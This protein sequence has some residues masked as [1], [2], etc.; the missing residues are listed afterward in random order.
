MKPKKDIVK[1]RNLLKDIFGVEDD[2]FPKDIKPPGRDDRT[3]FKLLKKQLDQVFCA[4][5]SREQEV[6]KM[7]F[8]LEDGYSLTLEEVGRYFNVTRERIREIEGKALRQLRDPQR[9]HRLKDYLEH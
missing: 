2:S 3:A 5:P 7:R 9:S 4:L 1:A 6:L 8:G